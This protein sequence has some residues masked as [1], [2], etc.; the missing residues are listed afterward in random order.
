MN[1]M[2]P[3]CRNTERPGRSEV[4]DVLLLQEPDEEEDEQED[5]GDGRDE[6]EDEEGEDDD[7]YSE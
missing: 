4:A 3:E 6:D 1:K 2:H 5:D 7:G